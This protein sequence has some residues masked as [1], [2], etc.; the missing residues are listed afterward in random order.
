MSTLTKYI[1]R[2]QIRDNIKKSSL[3]LSGT[4]VKPPPPLRCTAT[5]KKRTFV[6]GFPK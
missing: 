4:P 3:F 2:P 5:K 1:Q 6:C